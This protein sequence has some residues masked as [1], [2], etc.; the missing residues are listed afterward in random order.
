MRD[1]AVL[2]RRSA[3]SAP[4]AQLN[5]ALD[6]DRCGD[7]PAA[8]GLMASLSERLPFWDEAPLRLAE[9][10]RRQGET[11]QAIIAYETVLERNPR[12][13]EALLALGVMRM[14]EGKV[15]QAQS[16]LLQCCGVAPDLPEAWDAL[17]MSLLLS[18][19]ALAAESAF[20]QAQC[21]APD[22]ITFAQHRV[23]AAFAAGC[24]L[25]EV[26]RLECVLRADPTN[27]AVLTALGL[28][29]E[30]LD[31]R[32]EAIDHLI[33]ASTLQPREIIPVATLAH[34][35]VRA[36]RVTEALAAFDR[37]LALLPDSTDPGIRLDLSNNRAA[38]LIRLH[39]YREA[40]DALEGLIAQHGARTEL[41]NNLANA[42]VSLGRQEEGANIAR[43]AIA[44]QPRSHL[45]W[46]SLCNA[47][48]Y[49]A[50]TTG[51]D[52]RNVAESAGRI[53]PRQLL[54]PPITPAD[55]ERRLRIGL[56]SSTL[57]THPV[58]WLTIAGFENL[59]P[60][61]FELHAIGAE[62]G[63]D[64]INRRFR[65]LAA[66]WTVPAGPA[67]VEHIR[68]L[69]LDILI[70]LGGYGDQGHLPLCAERL[71]PVQ[72]KWVG[73]QNHSTG[74]AE[75]DWFLSD[76]VETPAGFESFYTERLLR[77]PDGYVCYSPPAYAP[78]VAPLPALRT[79]AITF[80]CFNNLAKVTPATIE[81]WATILQSIEGARL[82]MKCHQMSDPATREA[83]VAGFAAHGIAADRIELRG[84]SPH[85]D[86]LAQ[87][88]DIDIMLDPFPYS[89]GLMTC[90]ALWM[91]VPV[92]TM[93]GDI[94]A[95]RHSASHLANI[96]LGDWVAPDQAGYRAMAIARAADLSALAALRTGLRARVKASPLCD[97]PRF[98][99][100][101]GAA[102]RY[103]WRDRCIA[104]PSV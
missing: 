4:T 53:M 62:H 75:M 104:R 100:H 7:E 32:A 74:L 35:L 8:R 17:G 103:V 40:A 95:S 54:L 90:E 5:A 52:L 2:D 13:P 50:D 89:G 29:F 101:L 63:A 12:R 18:H 25:E 67:V 65:H 22:T 44:E 59:D 48:P 55:P 41:L 34:C 80:G 24:G 66:S 69:A 61:A 77:L 68:A 46:R 85:R 76:A 47:L 102:L 3:L 9:S 83:V 57:K 91:G 33:L 92:I 6:A 37:A 30:R 98:G 58:G 15:G 45:A 97:G 10:Y 84:G 11:A 81:V 28:C 51:A 87:H 36:N 88:G 60:E 94:F 1:E 64:P 16:L 72:I 21:L 26:G 78:D 99:R 43:R 56:L 82:V 79:G 96:G 73:S 42:L 27:A 39:R 23:E 19:D 20:A 31:R 86:L 49:C 14:A 70:D 71:A 38:T 93:P